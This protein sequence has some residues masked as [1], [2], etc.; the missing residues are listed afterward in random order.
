MQTNVTT[1]SPTYPVAVLTEMEIE[2]GCK[3]ELFSD[4]RQSFGRL[5]VMGADGRWYLVEE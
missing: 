2:A 4:I 5:F 1:F 3:D